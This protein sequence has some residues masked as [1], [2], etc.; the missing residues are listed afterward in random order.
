MPM[1]SDLDKWAKEAQARQG[2]AKAKVSVAAK[3]GINGYYCVNGST[4]PM[5]WVSTSD[6]ESK[7]VTETRP[8]S[9]MKPRGGS[10]EEFAELADRKARSPKTPTTAASKVRE[11][12]GD[13]SLRSMP[14][15]CSP[16]SVTRTAGHSLSPTTRPATAASAASESW[17][18]GS[19]RSMSRPG[20]SPR[21][22]SRPATPVENAM[23]QGAVMSRPATQR[24]A[25]LPRPG[26]ARED[27]GS[28]E[29]S[30]ERMWRL[31][32]Q[33][34]SLEAK[35]MAAKVVDH[36]DGVRNT[37]SEAKLRSATTENDRLREDLKSQHKINSQAPD[38]VDRLRGQVENLKT[39]VAVLELAVHSR[40]G[41]TSH[42]DDSSES[43]ESSDSDSSS[44]DEDDE[45]KKKKKKKKSKK[46]KKKKNS[47][48]EDSSSG[49][50]SDK[51]KKTK[52]KKTTKKKNG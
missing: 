17:R 28:N 20:G 36:D 50:D 11:G 32:E 45:K 25:K 24:E 6:E 44:D 33:V 27:Y 7:P 16:R 9:K 14:R 40:G 1:P 46:K 52:K 29:A 26:D 2:T 51:W 34:R 5:H 12:D 41:G 3:P 31:E 49:S 47:K 21:S 37:A 18:E 4:D 22:I 10:I 15:P 13:N 38:T 19:P 8:A 35:L 43:S 48:D 42:S 23:Q 30:E 39:R